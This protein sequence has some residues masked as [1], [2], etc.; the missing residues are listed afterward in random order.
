MSNLAHLTPP[1]NPLPNLISVNG[2]PSPPH[3]SLLDMITR[4]KHDILKLN[5][6]Y[7]SHALSVSFFPF[8]KNLIHT[9]RDTN[10]KQ[11]LKEEFD[12]LVENNTWDLVPQPSNV[13]VIRSLWSFWVKTKSNGSFEHYKVHLVGGGKSQGE[14]TVMRLLA[15]WSN[16]LSSALF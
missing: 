6:K 10:W 8:P 7:T 9:L 15:Q 12:A 14:G 13:N 1:F 16:P 4:S 11:A 5:P 2:I 3:P